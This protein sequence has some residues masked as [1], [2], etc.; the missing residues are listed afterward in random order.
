MSNHVRVVCRVRPPKKTEELVLEC[1]P[2]QGN[3]LK[4]ASSGGEPMSFHSV[5][6]HQS[7]QFDCYQVCGVPLVEALMAGQKSCLFAYVRLRLLPH[8]CS[9]ACVHK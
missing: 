8:P 9:P 2:R 5:L 1:D 4:L 3:T 7:T 6:G